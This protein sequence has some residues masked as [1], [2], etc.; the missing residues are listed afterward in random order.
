MAPARNSVAS[1]TTSSIK[2]RL[3]NVDRNDHVVAYVDGKYIESDPPNESCCR[4][5]KVEGFITPG[6]HTLTTRDRTLSPG[7]CS[8]TSPPSNKVVFS[9][10]R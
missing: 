10:L 3:A 6:M 2:V 8:I 9:L 4:I 1:I 7:S 5:F